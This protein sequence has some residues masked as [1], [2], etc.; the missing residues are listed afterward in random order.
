MV[1]RLLAEKRSSNPARVAGR[2]N[3]SSVQHCTKLS[4]AHCTKRQQGLAPHRTGGRAWTYHTKMRRH[5]EGVS[6]RP[7]QDRC[8][9]SGSSHTESLLITKVNIPIKS[10]CFPTRYTLIL[11]LCR[12][13]HHSQGGFYFKA[14]N[15][16]AGD[17]D[18]GQDKTVKVQR[19]RTYSVRFHN[20][21]AH[22]VSCA[23]STLL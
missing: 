17:R 10:S 11:T 5:A 13:G 18:G 8:R 19:G 23:V 2:K 14:R 20:F 4:P 6:G 15:F 9:R 7:A 1:I 16:P 21:I 22:L 12:P 3:N